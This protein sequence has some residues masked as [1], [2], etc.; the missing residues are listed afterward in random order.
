MLRQEWNALSQG[1]ASSPC[2][3][4]AI[5]KNMQKSLIAQLDSVQSLTTLSAA[6][7][8]GGVFLLTREQAVQFLTK[9]SHKKS[10]WIVLTITTRDL[11]GKITGKKLMEES[12]FDHPVSPMERAF[13]HYQDL[14]VPRGLP[15]NLLRPLV[16]DEEDDWVVV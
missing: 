14:C 7:D 4:F 13:F 9:F 8:V 5:F 11:M 3:P 15:V 2:K 6:D 10:Q 16:P 1:E 12:F